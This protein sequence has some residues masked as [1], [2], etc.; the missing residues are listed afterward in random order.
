MKLRSA[1]ARPR[2]ACRRRRR[3]RPT[4]TTTPP[5]PPRPHRRRRGRRH[6]H[7]DHDRAPAAAC[8]APPPSPPRSARASSARSSPSADGLTLYGF[9]NDVD[10]ISTCYSTCAEAWPPVIVDEEWTVGPGLDTGIFSTTERDDGT[11][12]LVAGKFPLYT[13]AA[14]PRPA[15]S[16]ARAPATCGSPSPSTAR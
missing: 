2:R 4:A 6:R 12:Q 9:V 3:L 15:T 13:S 14:T 16:P 1:P 8:R 5:R 11:L 7:A 10:A